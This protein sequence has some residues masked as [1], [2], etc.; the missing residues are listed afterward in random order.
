[1]RKEIR[2][3]WLL[4]ILVLFAGKTVG[5]QTVVREYRMKQAGSDLGTIQIELS[6]ENDETHLNTLVK[7]P[8]LNTEIATNYTFVGEEFPKKPYK[9]NFSI[10]QGG[11]LDLEMVWNDTTAYTVFQLGQ[12]NTIPIN[13]VLALDN[14]VISD[15]MVSTWIFDGEKMRFKRAVWFYRFKFCSPISRFP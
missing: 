13:N 10:I 11:V 15:Y 4:V 9:Y 3:V 8:S 14:N 2:L 7:Y 6:V 12:T 5:A 1:M